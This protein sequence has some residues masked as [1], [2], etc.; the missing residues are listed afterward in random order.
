MQ[1]ERYRLLAEENRIN[2][3]LIPP[4]RGLIFDRDGRAARRQPAELPHRHGARAGRRPRRRC[5]PG[6]PTIID[7]AAG[8]AGAGAEAR[9]RARSAFV[10]VVVAEHLTW[11]DV[12]AGLGERPGAARRDPRG[13]AQPR[14]IP[15]G[16]APRMCRLR[17]AGLGD[18]TSR[19]LRGPRPA[20]ADPALPDRQD[21]RRGSRLEPQLRG[22]GRQPEDR[23]QRRRPGDARARPGRGHAGQGHRSSPRPG[24]AELRDAAHG[25]RERR[26]RR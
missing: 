10:P 11:D 13:R 24:A 4:A 9:W 5:W 3:R 8:R 1:N 20:A 23:G 6:S 26:R 12:V 7:A 17:R 25:G 14:P 21:R 22:A 15:T 16:R 2:I 19:K 18:A